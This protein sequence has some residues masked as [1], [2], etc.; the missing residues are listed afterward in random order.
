MTTC[1]LRHSGARVSDTFEV[2]SNDF[3]KLRVK[4]GFSGHFSGEPE[5][6]FSVDDPVKL[7]ADTVRARMREAARHLVYAAN[8]SADAADS[9]YR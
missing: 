7:L 9:P 3:V 1:F 4:L 5:R 6:W 2:E 8:A